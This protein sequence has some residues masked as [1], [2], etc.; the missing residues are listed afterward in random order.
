ELQFGG[1]FDGYDAFGIGDVS[2]E[3]VQD[4]SFSGAGAAGD[5][6]VQ[7]ALDHSGEEFEHLSGESFVF[8]HVASGD[9]IAA[10]AADGKAGSVEGKR[11]NDG[12]DAGA[13]LEAGI[14][15]GRGFIDAI[16]ENVGDRRILEQGFE[17]AEAEDF[18]ENFARQLLA[19]GKAERNGLA[20]HGT[21]DED[22]N[23]FPS[24]VAGGA[25]EFFE[26]EAIENLAMQV[27][28]NLLVLAAFKGL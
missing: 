1:V 16:D 8:D 21:A 24:R 25:T 10:E 4:G 17:G 20:V 7:A 22:E 5:D 14:D 6:E 18:I 9:G 28:L 19:F 23:F 11:G 26:I 3:N 13:I 15:H 27:R 12:V 2:G